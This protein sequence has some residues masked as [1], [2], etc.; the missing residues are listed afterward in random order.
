MAKNENTL[1]NGMSLA[2]ALLLSG[3]DLFLVFLSTHASADII[4]P[5]VHIQK[6][7][8]HSVQNGDNGKGLIYSFTERVDSSRISALESDIAA[9]P[10]HVDIQKTCDFMRGSTKA[11]LIEQSGIAFDVA[12]TNYGYSG[13]TIACVLKYMHENNVGTQLIYSKKGSS[14]CTWYLSPTKTKH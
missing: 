14:G 7:G 2:Q 3:N 9:L 12:V 4:D 13:S 5:E 8:Y 6:N 1:L 11:L 10:K